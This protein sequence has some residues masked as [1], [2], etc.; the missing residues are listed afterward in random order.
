MKRRAEVALE[1]E[2]SVDGTVPK[3]GKSRT[4]QSST[5]FGDL[6]GDNDVN[7]LPSPSKSATRSI[8]SPR[9]VRTPISNPIVTAELFDIPRDFGAVTPLL[10]QINNGVLVLTPKTP[11]PTLTAL[12]AEVVACAAA[13]RS[14]AVDLLAL[15]QDLKNGVDASLNPAVKA[16]VA[17]LTDM[18]A[19]PDMCT[20]FPRLAHSG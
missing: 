20:E 6:I 15:H 3:Q 9:A 2:A 13:A 17:S 18:C 11:M 14:R 7:A 12:R 4:V 8:T 16:A 10:A 1:S 19:L 5:V